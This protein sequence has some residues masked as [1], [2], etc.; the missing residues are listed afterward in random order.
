MRNPGV[1]WGHP[2][3]GREPGRVASLIFVACAVGA[4]AGAGAVFSLVAQ[5]G[6][7]TSIGAAHPLGSVV[8]RAAAHS[9]VKEATLAPSRARLASTPSASQEQLPSHVAVI[10]GISPPR[11]EGS[12][13]ATAEITAVAPERSTPHSTTLL[14]R[15]LLQPARK[16]AQHWRRRR[17]K[18]RPARNQPIYRDM[19]GAAVIATAGV[20]GAFSKIVVGALGSIGDFQTYRMS[21]D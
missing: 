8:A 9:P 18:R 13:S 2:G 14:S 12:G 1:D 11:T 19:R 4:I 21:A 16:S 6:S 10:E 15:P 20:G 17:P 3:L 7:E 5:P